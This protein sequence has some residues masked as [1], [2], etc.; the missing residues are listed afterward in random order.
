MSVKSST[1]YTLNE[2]ATRI[3][4]A[5]DGQRSIEEIAR[6]VIAEEYEVDYNTAMQDTLALVRRLEKDGLLLV[7]EKPLSAADTGA[8]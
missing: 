3:W 8:A 6:N 5:A 7:H 4:E 1:L 2:S